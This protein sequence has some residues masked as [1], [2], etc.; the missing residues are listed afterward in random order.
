MKN[1]KLVYVYT[2]DIEEKLNHYKIGS[3]E[4]NA[5]TIESAAM[6]R[7]KEQFTA[8]NSHRTPK[9][10]KCFDI[11]KTKYNSAIHLE[12]ALHTHLKPYMCKAKGKTKSEWFELSDLSMIDE[13]YNSIINSIPRKNNFLLRS[14]QTDAIQKAL[15][16]YQQDDTFLFNAIMR[17][18]KT[19]SS[20]E[21]MRKLEA[22]KILVLTYKPQVR[23]EWQSELDNH[24]NY[25]DYT[26]IDALKLNKQSEIDKLNTSKN[27][28][29]FSS[30]QDILGKKFDGEIKDKFK[31]LLKINFDFLII[32]EVHYGF[33]TENCQN[34]IGK[35]N[36]KKRLDL[37]GTPINLLSSG[38]YQE[39]QIYSWTYIDEKKIKNSDLSNDIYKWLPK[40]NLYTYKVSKE[41][42]KNEDLFG[43]DEYLTLNKFFG[44]KDNRFINQSSVIRFLDNLACN[45]PR[46]FIGPFNDDTIDDKYLKHMFWYLS[47]VQEC[48]TMKVILE[49]H[50]FF[51]KY[52]IVVAAGDNNKEGS[53][54]LELVKDII[55]RVDKGLEKGKEF[56]GTITLSCGK[57]N[58]GVSIPEWT[59]V[60]FL[61]DIQSVQDYW[62]TAFRC[63]T[64]NKVIK[65]EQCYIFDFNPQRALNMM[66]NYAIETTKNSGST[67]DT[68]REFLECMR[69]LAYDGG[70]LE[71]KNIED[72]LKMIVQ[73]GADS[74]NSVKRFNSDWIFTRS[75]EGVNEE[76]LDILKSVVGSKKNSLADIQIENSGTKKGKTHIV[77]KG[78]KTGEKFEVDTFR[79]DFQDSLRTITSRIPTFLFISKNSEKNVLDILNTREPEL[80]KD[81]VGIEVGEFEKLVNSGMINL[82]R[83]T[84]AIE[85][86]HI[87][88]MLEDKCGL[89]E[90]LK[91]KKE[92]LSHLN[93]YSSQE[94]MTPIKLVEEILDKMDEKVWTLENTWCDPSVKSGI[95]LL[96]IVIRLLEKFGENKYEYII[97]EGLVDGFALSKQAELLVKACLPGIDIR[98][99]IKII[100]MEK[101]EMPKFD[102]VIMNPPY[103]DNTKKVKD[104]A[105]GASLRGASLWPKFVEKCFEFLKED[106]YLAA[107]HPPR[108]R[109]P[110]D[111]MWNLLSKK[112]MEY[113]SI[114]SREEGVKTFGAT[115]RYDWYILQNKESYKETIIK[116][117]KGNIIEKNLSE[118]SWL[119]NY[120]IEE[121]LNL[122]AKEKDD[123]L[124]I[125][126][127]RCIYHTQ[128]DNVSKTKNNIHK[129]PC[130]YYIG[131]TTKYQYSLNNIGHFGIPKVII[132]S[133]L[134]Q[135]NRILFDKNGD[136]GMTEFCFGIVDTPKNLEKIYEVTQ[137]DK[138]IDYMKASFMGFCEIDRKVLKTFRKD[139]WKEFV[140]ENG[141]EL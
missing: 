81:V 127:D 4:R 25:A 40:I 108:W 30:F 29:L 79:D 75:V 103:Q 63:K 118:L 5:E 137:T 27:Y 115:T 88:E 141:K 134:I 69:V 74:E 93:P 116:D 55:N 130:L 114:H 85:S 119:P 44:V 72:I 1:W 138:F 124:K 77:F 102:C 87:K 140:D 67:I 126:N 24:I 101:K 3:A 12:S 36:Y 135:K 41:V 73:V 18:G 20:Y 49:E 83:L 132:S 33:A 38:Y 106:G 10:L 111:K 117:E 32:D 16:Y 136:Y 52:R 100:D 43:E 7:I 89:I 62:Q 128:N 17:F 113:L 23:A 121:I 57:L 28:V 112:Q 109:R 15:N 98:S 70:T 131:P 39:E 122:V 34:F 22:K 71:E 6:L 61:S 35:I 123:K 95:F 99:D 9:L 91:K 129:Y 14:E 8:A 26:F 120:N 13:A 65:K 42:L 58:T 82:F 66:Y 76:V 86:F 47:G 64:M 97:E 54:T 60:F 68:I 104:K 31:E 2:D 48:K 56:K 107:I 90:Q 50:E 53:D 125:N 139:F 92:L 59:S 96:E 45:E 51:K 80:F 37:S 105:H 46:K 84:K 110:E 78:S 11:S 19:F 94:I 21:L 133:G